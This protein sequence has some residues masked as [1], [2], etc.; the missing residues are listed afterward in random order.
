MSREP[1]A[2]VVVEGIDKVALHM[3]SDDTGGVVFHL[4]TIDGR[5]FYFGSSLQDGYGIVAHLVVQIRAIGHFAE[6]AP[7]GAAN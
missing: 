7:Q 1:E 2:G 4:R 5:D 6:D 3:A